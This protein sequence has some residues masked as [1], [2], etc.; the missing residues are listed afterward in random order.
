MAAGQITQGRIRTDVDPDT[1]MPPD[2]IKGDYWK[3]D[4][5]WYGWCPADGERDLFCFLR[6][7]NVTTFG[8]MTVEGITVWPSILCGSPGRQWHGFLDYGVWREI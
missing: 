6:N 3:Y 4:G 1:H 2:S 5:Y 8:G 7:H